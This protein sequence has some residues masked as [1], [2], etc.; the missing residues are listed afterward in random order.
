MLFRSELARADNA[1]RYGKLVLVAEPH[2]LG[3][4]RAALTP[5]VKLKVE[6]EFNREM[7]QG[8]DARILDS[9]HKK[10][11]EARPL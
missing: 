8:A 7:R 4:L 2:F 9:I 11:R 1:D 10:M 5:D 6:H 3:L